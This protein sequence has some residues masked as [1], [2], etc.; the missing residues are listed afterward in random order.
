MEI[1]SDDPWN[2]FLQAGAI[3]IRSTFHTSLQA[4][5]IPGR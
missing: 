5:T 2:E 1:D 3:G 4:C